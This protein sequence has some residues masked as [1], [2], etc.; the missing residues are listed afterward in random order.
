MRATSAALVVLILGT[1]TVVHAVTCDSFVSEAEC[2]GKVTDAGA[3]EFVNGACVTGSTPLP[4]GVAGVTA[5][6]SSSDFCSQP[7]LTGNCR[8][9]FPSFYFDAA[10]NQCRQFVYGGCGG[11]DN[12]FETADACIQAAEEF[13]TSGEAVTLESGSQTRAIVYSV[14]MAIACVFHLI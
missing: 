14:A 12:R 13:C 8:G 10:S 11:N 9:L 1:S 4:D 6:A 5:V 7:M 2:Q 3:C